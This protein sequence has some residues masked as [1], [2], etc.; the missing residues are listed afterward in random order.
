MPRTAFSQAQL[1]K[2]D[3]RVCSTCI[4]R[5]KRNKATAEKDAWANHRCSVEFGCGKML[6]REEFTKKQRHKGPRRF[7]VACTDGTTLFECGKCH[8]AVPRKIYASRQLRL[9]NARQCP[10]CKQCGKCQRYLHIGSYMICQKQTPSKMK[11]LQKRRCDEC[12]KE[13]DEELQ[14]IWR[15][16]AARRQTGAF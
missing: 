16:D 11:T 14:G 6:P 9:G 13:F 5:A 7:C 4:E 8:S 15:A 3:S 1:K 12:L 2:G 10:N